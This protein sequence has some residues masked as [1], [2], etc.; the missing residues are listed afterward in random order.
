MYGLQGNPELCCSANFDLLC[1]PAWGWLWRSTWSLLRVDFGQS[2]LSRS[3]LRHLTRLLD[4][5]RSL[6]PWIFRDVLHDFVEKGSDLQDIAVDIR[7]HGNCGKSFVD[8]LGR[9]LKLDH[10]A[11]RVARLG[12]RRRCGA[13]IGPGHG[14]I[15]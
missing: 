1:L 2:R 5:I 8:E 4:Q 14:Y 9:V 10:G 12:L 11:L 15:R 13:T 3:L 6:R 7:T